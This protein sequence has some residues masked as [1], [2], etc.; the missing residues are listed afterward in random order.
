[1]DVKEMYRDIKA[2]SYDR[3]SNPLF[4]AILISWC[5]I[6]HDIVL[7]IFSGESFY[8]KKS[9]IDYY[10]SGFCGYTGG[11]F[12]VLAFIVFNFVLPIFSGMAYLYAM[13]VI[14]S[15]VASY[16]ERKKTELINKK[17]ENQGLQ[18]VTIE[19]KKEMD[20]LL[21]Q[22]QADLKSAGEDKAELKSQLDKKHESMVVIVAN[23]DRDIDKYKRDS[24]GNSDIYNA[25]SV[26]G[27]L[28]LVGSSTEGCRS[29]E[30]I[31]HE[32]DAVKNSPFAK[33][34]LRA[35]IISC[36]GEGAFNQTAGK[37]LKIHYYEAPVA[38]SPGVPSEWMVY[39]SSL[40][41]DQFKFFMN[42]YSG[43]DHDSYPRIIPE[44]GHET[45][46]ELVRK[47]MLSYDDS[48]MNAA[49]L[50]KKGKIFLGKFSEISHHFG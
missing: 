23:K 11:I 43:P 27:M 28:K 44:K 42:Y 8:E 9:F 18:L 15:H 19:E 17:R 46:S 20:S 37:A 13:P 1:M 49:L 31:Y 21:V 34:L 29:M 26:E 38:P 10:Y 47:G 12:K 33:S 14:S 6:N 48:A 32:V 3:A 40:S 7:V 30:E 35:N 41:Y 22:Y 45:V 25:V 39:L 5:L 16:H 4:S 24:L 2:A 50:T 36:F